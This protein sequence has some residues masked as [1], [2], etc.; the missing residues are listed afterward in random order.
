[1]SEVAR[2]KVLED[3]LLERERQDTSWDLPLYGYSHYIQ[4]AA[5]C[6]ALAETCKEE[7]TKNEKYG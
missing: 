5:I 7:N 2:I 6:F 3:V 1:M 4:L